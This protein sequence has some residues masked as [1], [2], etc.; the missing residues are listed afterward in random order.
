MIPYVLCENNAVMH[1]SGDT[2]NGLTI[3]HSFI[4]D[5]GDK[6]PGVKSARL[7]LR[8]F[9]DKLVY[10]LTSV[11]GSENGLPAGYPFNLKGNISIVDN[12]AYVW[13][14]SIDA[15]PLPVPIGTYFW[16]LE[17]V[18]NLNIRQTILTGTL[19]V[20]KDVTR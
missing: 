16:D 4:G 18:N 14:L 9:D 15:Q 6:P 8:D 5:P 2:W 1:Y 20:C 10:E 17:I 3:K 11:T 7:Q 12:P 19:S 13:I